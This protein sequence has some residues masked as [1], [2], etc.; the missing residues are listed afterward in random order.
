MGDTIHTSAVSYILDAGAGFNSYQW[1]TSNTSQSYTANSS[2][3]YC[4]TVTDANNCSASDC[5]YVEFTV[6]VKNDIHANVFN[7]YPNPSNGIVTLEFQD[8]NS[9]NN[10]KILDIT[11]KVILNKKSYLLKETID[12]SFLSKGIYIIKV[13]DS[14]STSANR[15]V[16]E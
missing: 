6:G 4:V 7:L 2:G 5:A 14:K 8:L 3:N 16:I 15:L 10:F 1:S 12:L 9:A 11:G 13:S